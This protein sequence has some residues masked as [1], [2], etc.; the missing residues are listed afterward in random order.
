VFVGLILYQV[1]RVSFFV[2]DDVGLERVSVVNQPLPGCQ[3]RQV[4]AKVLKRK[5]SKSV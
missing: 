3:H 2:L 5:L 1:G 4:G